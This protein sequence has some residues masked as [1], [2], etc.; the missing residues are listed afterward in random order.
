M[1]RRLRRFALPLPL[2]FCCIAAPVAAQSFPEL[3]A[4]LDDH[5]SLV[6]LRLEA[7]AQGDRARAAGALPDPDVTLGVANLPVADPAFDRFLPT[8]KALGVRQALPD[9]LTRRARTARTRAKA[10]TLRIQLAAERAVLTAELIALLA[11]REALASR[12]DALR[13]QDATYAELAEAVE[14]EIAG[15]RAVA[16]RLGAVDAERA[17]LGRAR[18]ALDAEAAR[19]DAGL[20]DLVG[21]VPDGTSAPEVPLPRWSGAASAFYA[22]AL[23]ARGIERAEAEVDLAR[24]AY[25]PDWGVSVTYQQR[26]ASGDG[27]AMAFPDDDW[28]T[29]QVTLS[30]PLYAARSQAPRLRAARADQAAAEARLQAA[31]R[32]ARARFET[33]IAEA[34]AAE[35]AAAAIT[36][37]LAALDARISASRTAYEAGYGDYSAVLDG[38]VARLGLEAGLATERARRAGAAAR[39]GSLLR[40]E[41]AR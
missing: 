17:A 15:G 40:A 37:Q 24:G 28:V 19:I 4:R 31:A 38:E 41:D 25:R 10:S 36:A 1:P 26:E 34:R 39:A 27:V 6:A 12:R 7:D 29:A 33:L 11:D 18:A 32:R 22:V 14:A 21:I 2:I 35:T 20:L 8:H 13:R 9:G 5:P 16:F 30:V 23:A 3:T